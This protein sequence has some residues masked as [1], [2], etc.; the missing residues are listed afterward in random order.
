MIGLIILSLLIIAGYTTAVCI[1]TKGI[2]YSI[3]ATYYTLDHKLIF[4]AC[5][6][7]TAMFLFPV[8]WE[9]STS[10]TMQLLAVAACAGLLGVGLAP[11]FK[12]T[13]IN[14]V[15]CTS[16]AVTLICS[17]LWVA[18]TPIWW[19]L[20]PVWTLYIIYTVWY[21]A[22]HVTDSIVS[23]FIRTRPMFWVEVAALTSLIISIIV[24]T[25]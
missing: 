11:D 16:A 20:I 22:K 1:K 12:D 18:L 23:D 14:K 6:A 2:P 3:S 8:V 17:Q 25:P 21:M 10:F 4:G 5:M 13:W 19:V 7:L 9:L 24:L 15:H